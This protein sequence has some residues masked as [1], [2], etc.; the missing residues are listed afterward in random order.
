MQSNDGLALAQRT[1][2]Q[3]EAALKDRVYVIALY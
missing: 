2:P 1:I 3:F